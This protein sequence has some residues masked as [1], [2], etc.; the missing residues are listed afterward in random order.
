MRLGEIM[1]HGYIKAAA[2][3]PEIRVADCIYNRDSIIKTMK[4]ASG[5]G[6]KVLVLPELC[7]TGYTCGDLF[8]QPTL[9]DGALDALRQIVRVSTGLKLLDVYKRQPSINSIISL[10]WHR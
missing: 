1:Q 2:G 3:T 9:L 6:A 7:I 10:T 8:L 4:A 5:Q